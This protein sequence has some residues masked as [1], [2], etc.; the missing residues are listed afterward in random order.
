MQTLKSYPKPMFHSEI[1]SLLPNKLQELMKQRQSYLRGDIGFDD[2]RNPVLAISLY[3]G[4][5]FVA[6]E[7]N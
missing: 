4:D 3:D 1:A 5:K 6:S 7:N 2:I